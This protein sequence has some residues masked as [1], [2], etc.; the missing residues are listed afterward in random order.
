MSDLGDLPEPFHLGDRVITPLNK[1]A[2]VSLVHGQFISGYYVDGWK[3]DPGFILAERYLARWKP[4][5]DRP[6][7]V[8]IRPPRRVWPTAT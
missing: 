8:S 4:G 5:A 3:S 2:I 6:A 7:P 1:L